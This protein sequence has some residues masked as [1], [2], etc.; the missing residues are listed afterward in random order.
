VS[1]RTALPDVISARLVTPYRLRGQ[2]VRIE[3]Q[4][5]KA[6]NIT[7]LIGDS[8]EL[9]VDATTHPNGCLFRPDESGPVSI[10]V[11][12]RFGT[13]SMDLG[14]VTL[15]ELPAFTVSLDYLPRP[16]IPSIEAFTLEPMI[17]ALAGAPRVE[18]SF[19]EMPSLRTLDLAKSLMAD[20]PSM[21]MAAKQV[22]AN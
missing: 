10:E 17:A 21:I 11:R 6:S 16:R 5:A 8:F 14:E 9:Q 3:W 1:Q 15:K 4:I 18:M 2:D 12:N 13:I 22:A 7:I 20:V 19:P